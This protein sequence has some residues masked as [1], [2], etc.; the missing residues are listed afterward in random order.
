[1]TFRFV[2]CRLVTQR[3]APA[4]SLPVISQL[5]NLEPAIDRLDNP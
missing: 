1:M 3:K 2:E 4:A 5:V